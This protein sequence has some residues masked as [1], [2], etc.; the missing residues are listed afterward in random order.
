MIYTI[1]GVQA[2]IFEEFMRAG[3]VSLNKGASINVSSISDERNLIS[4]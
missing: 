3:E 2:G 4:M 1:A